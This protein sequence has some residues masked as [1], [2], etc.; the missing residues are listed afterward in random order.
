M[1]L[2]LTVTAAVGPRS[3]RLRPP[4]NPTRSVKGGGRGGASS[5][6]TRTTKVWV[7]AKGRSGE[8]RKAS[9]S[10]D[11]LRSLAPDGKLATSGDGKWST[12][13]SRPSLVPTVSPMRSAVVGIG[14]GVVVSAFI[15]LNMQGVKKREEAEKQKWIAI[16]QQQQQQQQQQ[17]EAEAE[18]EAEEKTITLDAIDFASDRQDDPS[19]D[20]VMM[21][22]DE[23]DQA[24]MSNVF[25]AAPG[26]KPSPSGTGAKEEGGGDALEESR[27]DDG[28]KA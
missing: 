14:G 26:Q 7:A 5:H 16:A 17:Q 9:G 15:W 25:G 2:T 24:S 6:M 12:N 3:S 18:A 22:D 11:S 1:T 13:A 28:E 27:K 4:F 10:A 23:E 8:E 19:F 20:A 21:T